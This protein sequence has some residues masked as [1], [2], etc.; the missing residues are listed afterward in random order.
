MKTKDRLLYLSLPLIMLFA[1]TAL[2]KLLAPEAFRR[3]MLNQPLP[4][5]FSHQL[6]WLL[7]LA[8]LL[9]AGLLLYPPLQKWGFALATG[10]MTSFTSYVCL[11]LLGY[12]DYVPCSCGGMLEQLSW[13]QHL[14]VN[15]LFWALSLYGFY[16]TLRPNTTLRKA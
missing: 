2:S 3:A 14:G 10:L 7:P 8:E 11:I 16:T 9:T 15:L 13:E 1:Y 6:V 5:A 12:F 4:E